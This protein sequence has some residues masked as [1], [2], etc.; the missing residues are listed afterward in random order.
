MIFSD[1][2]GVRLN[3][4]PPEQAVETILSYLHS[5]TARYV[6]TVNPEF[7]MAGMEKQWFRDL[8]NRSDI[9][10]S[11]GIGIA[12]AREFFRKIPN[13]V[14]YMPNRFYRRWF[15]RWIWFIS[16]V[17]FAFH[18]ATDRKR[19]EQRVSGSDLLLTLCKECPEQ[20]GVFLV[21][22][23]PGVAAKARATLLAQNNRLSIVGAEMG[24]SAIRIGHSAISYDKNEN[25]QLVE[26]IREA[27]PSI[28][29]VAFGQIKQ[30]A[31]ITEHL[32]QFPSVRV[33]IGVGGTL[34]FIAGSIRRAPLFLQKMALEWLWRLM[35]E[36][37]RIARIWTAVVRFPRAVLAQAQQEV[38]QIS[39]TSN[40]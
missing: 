22:G 16:L 21:G 29:A 20:H 1:I 9:A 8:L 31:W 15:I 26:H 35:I 17:R 23:A 6:V 30:E 38:E 33:F 3:D 11:D 25:Q 18:S 12:W 2:L 34:D 32:F 27:R 24:L 39:V 10:L 14:P 36:P 4:I 5:P 28:V 37:K 7:L 19:H 13:W 40:A